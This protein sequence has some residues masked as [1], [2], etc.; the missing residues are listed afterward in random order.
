[1]GYAYTLFVK[2][3]LTLVAALAALSGVYLLPEYWPDHYMAAE[4][5]RRDDS[6]ALAVYL[7]R[8]LAP[9]DRTQWRSWPRRTV[10]RAVRSGTTSPEMGSAD[11]PLLSFALGT[12]LVGP[13]SLL[14]DAGADVGARGRDGATP[15]WH[16]AGCGN[17]ALVEAL[18]AR[19]ADVNAREPDG[20]TALWE[21][22]NLGWRQR[23]LEPRVIQALERAGAA[24]P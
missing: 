19:G 22:T 7:S 3:V 12:C 13:A 17:A 1:M 6:A 10:G 20:G 23:P 4:A 15:L 2:P 5:I 9:D 18:L 21:R 14:I 8:G 24:R 16:A 11:E